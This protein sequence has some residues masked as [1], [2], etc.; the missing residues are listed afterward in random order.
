MNKLFY[1]EIIFTKTPLKGYFRYYDLF[2]IYPA[3][4]YKMPKSNLQGHYPVV[5]EFWTSAKDKIDV[6]DEYEILKDLSSSTAT[7]LTKLD[8][9]LS[10]L[11]VFSNHI[12]FRYDDLK[13]SWGIS[14]LHDN[15]GDEAEKWSAT[16]VLPHYHWPE[17]IGQFQI[18]EFSIPDV[19]E[20]VLVRHFDYFMDNPNLDS[21]NQSNISF[22]ETIV[23][24]L[25][26][27]FQCS[28]NM[29]AVLDSAIYYAVSAMEMRLQ[30]K[31]L[32]LLSSFT[33]IETMVNLEYTG[34]KVD[35]CSSCSQPKFSV[36]QKYREFLTKYLGN[37]DYNKKKFNKYYSI[38]S[39]IVHTG[40]RLKT[41]DLY[42]N[43][44]KQEKHEE[45]VT[46]IEILQIG[47]LAIIQWLL[48]NGEKIK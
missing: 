17:M 2:Q 48:K 36:T 1:K 21:N 11:S 41:E 42:V 30:K 23:S 44:G 9:I 31:T 46:I 16:W 15:P 14:L 43:I 39:K 22:P 18:D 47:K 26:L 32:A 29:R 3:D 13:G 12:F 28:D 37:S 45:R 25:D 38:R 19:P 24:L 6:K 5:L 35:K 34:S 40:K 27:Y 8:R 7:K 33:S 20:I 10:L 4:F